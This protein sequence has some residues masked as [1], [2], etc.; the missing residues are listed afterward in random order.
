MA[1]ATVCSSA[2]YQAPTAPPGQTVTFCAVDT[3]GNH[4]TVLE[5]CCTENHGTISSSTSGCNLYCDLDGAALNST[6]SC[7]E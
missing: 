1:A 6:Q 2:F 7:M 3:F 5:T 4:T